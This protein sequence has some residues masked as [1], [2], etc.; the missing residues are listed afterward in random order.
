MCG[1]KCEAPTLCTRSRSNSCPDP[2]PAPTN[3]PTNT[4]QPTPSPTPQPTPVQTP[5]PTPKVMIATPNPTPKVIV[6]PVTSPPTPNPVSP[7]PFPTPPQQTIVTDPPSPTPTAVINTPAD[8]KNATPMPPS[9]VGNTL[10]RIDLSGHNY[11]SSP[12]SE[13]IP[14]WV[15]VAIGA[16]LCC[17]IAICFLVV[18]VKILTVDEDEYIEDDYM[19]Q[20]A[21]TQQP[22]YQQL[23][24]NRNHS[25][26]SIQ[27]QHNNNTHTGPIRYEQMPASSAS[28]LPKLNP[29]D[30][31]EGMSTTY[32]VVHD[33]ETADSPLT[34]N[35]PYANSAGNDA[36]Y[37][38]A[39]QPLGGFYGHERPLPKAA[40]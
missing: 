27:M 32:D 39:D 1:G 8:N 30:V 9:T 12:E 24:L 31:V 40:Y 10:P 3:P 13:G 23:A 34:I 22:S 28:T 36:G 20:P 14:W 25:N 37:V 15:W 35:N 2:T 38:T 7:T 21:P 29:Y 5:N 33:Y 19:A 6:A 26:N 17:S 11:N 16:A 4:P 18:I